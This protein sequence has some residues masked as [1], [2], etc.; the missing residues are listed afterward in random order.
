MIHAFQ[1]QNPKAIIKPKP[2][3]SLAIVGSGIANQQDLTINLDRIYRYCLTASAKDCLDAKNEFII[4]IF[5][6]LP[7]RMLSTYTNEKS[8][9]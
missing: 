1:A 3:D 7:V 4:K 6:Q 8:F 9:G 5:F 2:G